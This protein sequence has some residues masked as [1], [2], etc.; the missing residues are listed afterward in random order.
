MA[1]LIS[2]AALWGMHQAQGRADDVRAWVEANGIDPHDVPVEYDMVIE[3]LPDGPVIRYW[4]HARTKNGH[5]Y[6]TIEGRAAVEECTVP[7]VVEPPDGWPVHA[8]PDTLG[9]TGP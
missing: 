1:R 6:A 3:D 7:L 4:V 8:V 5:K 2:N 9:R